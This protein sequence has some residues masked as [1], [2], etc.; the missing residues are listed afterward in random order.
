M[1]QRAHAWI[2]IR[3]IKL[4][5]DENQVPSLIKLLK[6]YTQEASIGAWI[7]DKRDAKLGGGRTQNHI[8]K[9]TPYHGYLKS[10]FVLSRNK[11]TKRLGQGRLITGLLNK[12]TNILDKDWW[13]GAYRADPSPGK[14][15]ANRAMALAINNIDMC[16]LGD[17]E[18]QAF[19]PGTVG[20][21]KTVSTCTRC[22]AGQIA[23]FFFMLSH[24]IADSLMPCHCDER[25]LADYDKG[26]HKQLENHWSKVVGKY[27][28]DNGLAQNGLSDEDILTK[29]ATIDS[30]FG[31]R[32]TNQV[33][34]MN[35]DDVWEE[36]VMLCRSSFAV[37]SIIAP[38]GQYPYKPAPQNLAPFS[39]LF[40]KGQ[41]GKDLLKEIDQAIMHDAVLN[42]AIIWKYIW[43]KFD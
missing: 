14:H 6:P 12:Y 34:D 13:K 39:T 9:I 29:A 8:F 28:D 15:L 37:A 20:F 32:F 40:E 41:Q 10:R 3:A 5:E 18:V 27:F 33:P 26:L 1:D 7:P 11:L 23:L 2:A 17:P 24:F 25:D 35:S 36:L 4:L 43:R 30:K 38:P 19:V 22:A 42:V 16:I 21:I 31:I